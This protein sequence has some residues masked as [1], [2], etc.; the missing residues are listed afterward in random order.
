MRVDDQAGP[1]V[2][3]RTVSAPDGT[4]EVG[5][6]VDFT[7]RAR[8]LGYSVVLEGSIRCGHQKT[9]DLGQVEAWAAGARRPR[10]VGGRGADAREAARATA[11]SRE[12]AHG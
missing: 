1:A 8:L 5:E 10:V 2:L 3:F 11:P 7:W 4:V 6:D 12:A 9:V